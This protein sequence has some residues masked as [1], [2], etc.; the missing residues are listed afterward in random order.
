PTSGSSLGGTPLTIQGTAF[1]QGATVTIGG[2]TATN[3]T[4]VN[5][6][7]LLATS[8]PHAQGLVNAAVTHVGGQTGAVGNA[9]TYIPATP[10][11]VS[12]IVPSSGPAFG[13]TPV[14]IVGA[15]FAN[16]VSVMIGGLS[17]TNVTFLNPKMIVATTS[18]HT[19]GVA[20]V[21]LTNPDSQSATL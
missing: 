17:A 3:V 20:D 19:A 15:G 14:T 18:A 9:L 10:P 16:G 1:A 11:T 7:T 8:R 4:F 6:G 13:G 5:A 21:V 12:A 2:T